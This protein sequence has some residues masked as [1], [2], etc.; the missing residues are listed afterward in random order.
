MQS[1]PTA[2]GNIEVKPHARHVKTEQTR[3]G[4]PGNGDMIIGSAFL[5]TYKAGDPA[6]LPVRGGDLTSVVF[7]A[8]LNG[9]SSDEWITGLA[10]LRDPFQGISLLQLE[11]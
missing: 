9:G 4:L 1:S 8:T 10:G 7:S 2:W 6:D 3:P 11:M 5:P